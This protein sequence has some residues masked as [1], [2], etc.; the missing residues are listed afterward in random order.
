MRVV[1]MHGLTA[2]VE[3]WEATIDALRPDHEVEVLEL[4]RLGVPEAAQ[5]LAARLNSAD[6]EPVALVGHSSGG[7]AAVLAAV[8]APG[9]VE[10]LALIAPAGVF[11]SRSRL[12]YALPLAKEALQTRRRLPQMVRDTWRVGPWRLW[13]IS[14]GLL[15]VD[16]LPVLPRVEARTLVVWGADDPLLAPV[17]GE[18]FEERIP[19]ARLVTFPDC[20]HI[21]MLEAPERLNRELVE[22]LG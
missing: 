10:R 13:R 4:P 8:S 9:A 3:W 6:G 21:P 5:W 7:A 2:S 20:G 1:L 11:P 22:F 12:A 17:T 18:T 19:D 16:L 14:S 15:R